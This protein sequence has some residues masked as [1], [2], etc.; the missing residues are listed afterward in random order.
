MMDAQEFMQLHADNAVAGKMPEV[1]KDLT[2]ESMGQV[3][4]LMAGAAQPFKANK[5][6]AKGQDADAF[7]FNVTY[8]DS[9]GKDF[10][11]HEKVRQ[12]DGTWKI[13][14]LTKPE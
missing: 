13:V 3:G 1:L 7:Y 8:T 4:A 12:V 9:N 14:E 10:S 2:P 6:E 5:V 11:M